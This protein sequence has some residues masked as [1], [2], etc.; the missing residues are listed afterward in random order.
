MTIIEESTDV[1][2][3]DPIEATVEID[4][5]TAAQQTLTAIGADTSTAVLNHSR[6]LRIESLLAQITEA[7]EAI[8]QAR[9]DHESWMLRLVEVAHEVADSHEWCE[10]FDG[11]MARV[12]LPSRT[13]EVTVTATLTYEEEVDSDD[14]SEAVIR[15]ATGESH[16]THDEIEMTGTIEVTISVDVCH[17]FT[18]HKGECACSEYDRAIIVEDTP[19]W[20]DDKDFT[21]SLSCSNCC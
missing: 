21:I 19:A 12:G 1:W 20:I 15:Y 9:R 8:L 6:R 7:D 16:P 13:E 2:V 3:A 4:P 11:G 18:V 14:I 5:I 10:V 17:D